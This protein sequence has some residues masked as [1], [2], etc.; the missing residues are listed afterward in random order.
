MLRTKVSAAAH[1]S[2]RETAV[3]QT[4]TRERQTLPFPDKKQGRVFL[5][6]ELH[7]EAQRRCSPEKV[8]EVTPISS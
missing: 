2:P 4:D 5:I 6:G 7:T 8:R 1:Y 3:A